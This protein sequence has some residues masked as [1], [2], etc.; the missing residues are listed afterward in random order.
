MSIKFSSTRNDQRFIRGKCRR[1]E[2]LIDPRGNG[3]PFFFQRAAAIGTEIASRRDAAPFQRLEIEHRPPGPLSGKVYLIFL[4]ASQRLEFVTI[5][6]I[7]IIVRE[8]RK[9]KLKG[10]SLCMHL[11]KGF[12][13]LR[14]ESAV[15]ETSV[16]NAITF[17]G[18][19]KLFFDLHS[20][21]FRFNFLSFVVNVFETVTL[22]ELSLEDLNVLSTYP[23]RASSFV[24]GFLV[25]TDI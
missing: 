4:H 18:N 17:H 20:R 19:M 16:H 13:F 22:E 6:K 21:R 24:I 3:L 1:V 14:I 12:T 10:K 11:A 7:N 15:C 23:L 5:A 25:E 8:S 2:N 9:I